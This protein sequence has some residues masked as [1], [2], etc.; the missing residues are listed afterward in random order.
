[1]KKIIMAITILLFFSLILAAWGEEKENSNEPKQTAPETNNEQ[2]D[3]KPEEDSKTDQEDENDSQDSTGAD[4]ETGADDQLDLGIGDRGEFDTT[5]G[6]Y[7][8]TVDSA[9]L[10]DTE[11]DDVLP[12]FDVFIVLDLSIK[13]TSD[14]ALSL[15]DLIVSMEATE[16]LDMSG[17]SDI[18]GGFDS[19]EMITGTIEPGESVSGQFITEA[20]AS[21]EYYFRKDPGNITGGSSNQV[22]WTIK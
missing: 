20:Y 15:D 1:M 11:I 18:S 17:Y 22:I 10:V 8:M 16:D 3:N 7:E 21:E 14:Q 13:N 19:I 2:D 12:K 9:E 4:F 6:T 5:L